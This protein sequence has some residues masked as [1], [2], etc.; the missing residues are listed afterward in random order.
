MEDVITFQNSFKEF[1]KFI[2]ISWFITYSL[3]Y[4]SLIISKNLLKIKEIH[5]NMRW[6]FIHFM[7]NLII[8][9]YGFRDLVD[10]FSDPLYCGVKKWSKQS[11][12]SVITV[13]TAHCYHMII[14]YKYLKYDEWFHHI[15][16]GLFLFPLMYI[17][18][19]TKLAVVAVWFLSGLPGG[20]DYFLL[21][22]VKLR[23]LKK[24]IEKRVY[25]FITLFFRSP[26]CLLVVFIHL[27]F[28]NS[29]NIFERIIKYY[30]CI[31]VI[32][33]SQYYTY[34]TIKDYTK[35]Y[36]T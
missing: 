16:W 15:V 33:N 19:Q 31:L 29:S 27:L 4:L 32:L 35:N 1:I 30:L 22:L 12:F 24:Q 9:F 26:G 23:L 13:F 18:S 7:V 20:I 5:H 25:L 6:F 2:S 17:Y 34:V 21:W 36:L 14:F 10:C 28:D 11:Q 8:S 3:D